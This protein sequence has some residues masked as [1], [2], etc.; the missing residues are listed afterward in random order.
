MSFM[1]I[2]DTFSFYGMDVI[3]LAAVTCIAVQLLKK[4][5]MKNCKKKIVTFLPFLLGTLFYAAFAAVKRLDFFYIIE[6]YVE[7]YEH[8][9][10]VGALSTVIYVWYE[11]FIRD[12]SEKSTVESV[13][14]TLIEGYVPSEALEA[15]AKAI[16]EAIS[17]D[18]TGNGAAKAVEI[19]SANADEELSERDVQLLAKL[20]IETLAHLSAA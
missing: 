6:N 10:A 14:E 20:I 2:I 15:T 19:L 17:K 1:K 11:Q 18:V 13:I 8:G 3:L 16:A 7:V 9:F 5:V 4:S 12:K